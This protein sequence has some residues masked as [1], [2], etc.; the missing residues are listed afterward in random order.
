MRTP[1]KYIYLCIAVAALALSGDRTLAAAPLKIQYRL[2][3][4]QPTTHLVDVEISVTGVA[5]PALDFA[6]PAWAPGRY[7]IY[8]FAKNVQE[9]AAVGAAGQPLPWSKLD[10]QT[11][12][13]DARSAGGTVTV[14]Y[15]VYGNDLTGTFSQID[16]THASLAGPSLFMYVAGH[17]P[18][19]VALSIGAPAEW[20]T[21]SG[22]SESTTERAFTAP[23]YD[24]LADT[25]IE[26]CSQCTLE[27][28]TE[29]GKTIRVLI[30]SFAERDSDSSKLVEGL[31][32]IV[33]SELAMMPEPDLTHYTFLFH[34][35]PGVPMGDGMEHLDSTFIVMRN[36]LSD[37]SLGET[38]EIASHEFF[39]V[40][41][42][43]RLRPVGLGPFDYSREQY[44]NSLWFAEGVTTYYSFVHLYRAGLLDREEYLHRIAEEIRTL[45]SDPGRK[46]MSAESSSFHAWFYDR[47]PQMQQTNFANTT[48]SYYN[49]GAVLGLLLD[50]EIRARTEG[51]KSLDDVLVAM[52]SK[53]Y[54]AAQENYYLPGR[55]YE[56]K[57][58]LAAA[59]EVTGSDLTDFFNRYIQ[60]TEP[61]PYKSVLAAAGLELRIAT[62]EGAPPSL[63]IL[64]ARV[65]G[66][67][68]ITSV[69]PGS[70]AERGGLSRDDILTAVDDL[71]LTTVDLKDRLRMY[72]P[73]TAVPFTVER[74]GR[75]SRITVTLD[76]PVPTEYSLENLSG[77]TPQQSAVREGWLAMKR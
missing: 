38:L 39:H 6:M 66:G 20:K 43:K 47:S 49:K 68:A 14:R 59:N 56:D 40:W 8:D 64:S 77:A 67:V 23:N 70:A 42:V 1:R 61:L 11:W 25:P 29:G 53:F 52:Y 48:I 28:F 75:Q 63:G 31:K 34:F 19:P 24:R 69:R 7:A 54:S 33:H 17:I 37:G 15:R 62:P 36:S 41:N 60:G 26:L 2:S 65:P 73:G 13:V 30:H 72:P 71:S 10:K 12:H 27:T 22:F 16:S 32:A 45:E 55:G 50:L 51:R 57:D 76:P 4:L 3:I 58:I 21:V 35:A 44:S 5:D 46:L 74:H 18:D 9:F